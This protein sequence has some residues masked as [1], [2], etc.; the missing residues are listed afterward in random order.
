MVAAVSAAA[1][2]VLL[3]VPVA[4][5]AAAAGTGDSAGGVTASP[6]SASLQL[7]AW[8]P[9]AGLPALPKTHNTF[10]GCL[11]RA[12]VPAP[13]MACIF[14]VDVNNALQRDYARITHAW[15]IQLSL[16]LTESVR[17]DSKGNVI[18][19]P[20]VVQRSLNKTEVFE[21]T[22]LCAATNASLT[23]NLSP[24]NTFWGGGGDSPVEKAECPGGVF[25][26]CDPDVRGPDEEIE[27]RF[28]SMMV[29]QVAQWVKEANAQLGGGAS[30]R[31][32]GVLIDSERFFVSG[33]KNAYLLSHF[34]TEMINLPI[35]AQDKSRENSKLEAFLAGSNA[36]R[37][38]ALARKHD[39]IVN[40]SRLVCS[41]GSCT[42][43]QYNRGTIQ[44]DTTEAKASFADGWGPWPG[45]PGCMGE[46]R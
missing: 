15:P 39:L 17:R 40:V 28:W 22:R 41:T 7:Q 29:T 25:L 23:L 33:A 9:L 31:I 5:W 24:W 14:P 30:V 36:T 46:V 38:A 12:D 10:G 26:L 27:V 1:V 43:E 2:T 8:N 19:D 13:S 18:F 11:Y 44:R 21:A 42:I 37:L 3:T 32:G 16:G 6:L 4:G 20:T 34:Y 35:Q 45:Y